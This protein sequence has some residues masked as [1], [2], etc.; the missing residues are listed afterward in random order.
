[1]NTQK[2]LV[3]VESGLSVSFTPALQDYTEFS[4]RNRTKVVNRF[5]LPD[6]HLRRKQNVHFMTGQGKRE[7]GQL[8]V[9]TN[10]PY[11][12]SSHSLFGILWFWC[13]FLYVLNFLFS[14][15]LL[16]IIPRWEY[17][18]SPIICAFWVLFQL[19]LQSDFYWWWNDIFRNS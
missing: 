14:I 19:V 3:L 16:R 18:P 1:M 17:P 2:G 5:Q 10:N 11:D 13:R 12:G 4:I 6:L 9:T 15:S 7:S 8:N